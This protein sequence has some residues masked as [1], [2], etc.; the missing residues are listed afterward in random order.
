[1]RS[2]RRIDA[3]L[4]AFAVNVIGESFHVGEFVVGMNNALRVAL[5]GPGVVND[6]VFVSGS[7]HAAR[8][9]SV[10]LR[11]NRFVVNASGEMIPTVPA[12]GRRRS[13]IRLL[14][15]RWDR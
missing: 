12:H 6:D 2:G 10:G 9:H 5:P 11:A 14:S 13:E 1:F 7:F 3:E 4:Q 15:K 8:D